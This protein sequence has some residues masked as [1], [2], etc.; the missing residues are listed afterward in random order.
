MNLKKNQA[1]RT[2]AAGGLDYFLVGFL[3]SQYPVQKLMRR[4]AAKK[5]V[6]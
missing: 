1:A 6:L 4:K 2:I 3:D 5:Q